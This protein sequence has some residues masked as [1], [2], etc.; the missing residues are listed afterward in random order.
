MSEL[1]I[2]N[3]FCGRKAKLEEYVGVYAVECTRID[4][5][6]APASWSKT[7]AIKAWNKRTEKKEP[8]I[9]FANMNVAED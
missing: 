3:C 2:N 9:R 1:K 5:W 8:E 6:T 4:C 7:K